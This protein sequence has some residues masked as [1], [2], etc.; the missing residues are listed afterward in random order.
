MKSKNKQQTERIT[1]EDEDQM[2]LLYI[3]AYSV[4]NVVAM[5]MND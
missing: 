4:F 2:D 1:Q 3:L 5:M